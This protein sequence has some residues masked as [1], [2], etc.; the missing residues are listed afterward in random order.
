MGIKKITNNIKTKTEG[1]QGEKE[2]CF[3]AFF[4]YARIRF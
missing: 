3:R 2:L 1:A 4:C